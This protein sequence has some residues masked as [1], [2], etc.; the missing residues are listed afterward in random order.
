M[1]RMSGQRSIPYSKFKGLGVKSSFTKENFMCSL[2]NSPFL[3]SAQL[4]M[5]WTS[6]EILFLLP[7]HACL[8]A[9]TAV[10]VLSVY[11]LI[12]V[13]L[14]QKKK[15]QNCTSNLILYLFKCE[16][17]FQLETSQIFWILAQPVSYFI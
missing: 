2:P 6:F 5:K 3:L 14:Q 1:L 7:I 15:A 16:K 12:P 8:R 4:S 9:S 13:S 17:W 11:L 10:E